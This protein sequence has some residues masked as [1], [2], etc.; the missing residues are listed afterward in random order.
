MKIHSL[1][2]NY[3][4]VYLFNRDKLQS[5]LLENT[6][7]VIRVQAGTN[8]LWAL[9]GSKAGSGS[10]GLSPRPSQE[11]AEAAPFQASGIW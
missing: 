11:Q 6:E 4:I 1:K 5:I 7:N 8:A 2:L 3:G 9:R 10:Q